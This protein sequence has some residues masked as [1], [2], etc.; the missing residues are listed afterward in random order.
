MIRGARSTRA[1]AALLVA[2]GVVLAS[3]TSTAD[4]SPAAASS[5]TGTNSVAIPLVP[6]DL[7]AFRAAE[8]KLRSDA[9]EKAG[10]AKLGPGALELA[11]FMD[12]TASFLLTDVPAR[13]A[14]GGPSG[15][16]VTV[17]QLAGG[18]GGRLAAPMI[19]LPPPGAASFG[20]Y[21]MT[22]YAFSELM[23][24]LSEKSPPGSLT[25]DMKP[26]TDTVT[27]AGNKGIITTLVT[28]SAQVSASKVSVLIRTK[29]T[30]EV[31]SAATN[32]V[33]FKID[34]EATGSATGDACPDSSGVARAKVTFRG[35]EEY[36]DASGGK[37]GSSTEDYG[38]DIQF[39]TDDSAKLAS[40]DASPT[41]DV[42]NDLMMAF[43][44]KMAAPGFEKAWRSGICIEVV[45]D[46]ESTSVD[47]DSVTTVNVKLRH[48]IDG[49]DLDKTVE[50]T[51]S[52]AKSLD[53]VGKK[54]KSPAT[55]QYTAG[56]KDDDEG[57][58]NFETVS[59][60]GVGRT[61]V[62]YTVGGGTWTVTS[63]GSSNERAQGVTKATLS[64]KIS[65][66]IT[67]A[68]ETVTGAKDPTLTG[69]GTMTV[70]GPVSTLIPNYMSCSGQ[71]DYTVHLTVTGTRAG[72]GTDAVLRLTIG[73]NA[74]GDED[75]LV[76]DCVASGYTLPQSSQVAPFGTNYVYAIGRLDLPASGGT[77]SISH[78]VSIGEL[79]VDASGTFTVVHNKV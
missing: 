77:K 79:N 13:L 1:V 67:S 9:R 42:G 14:A 49:N 47:R 72:S 50:A 10:L 7:A 18:P 11:G 76:M 2:C 58:M 70:T 24:K 32:A 6:V 25:T 62:R 54:M 38:S 4:Q 75:T 15:A 57:T 36:F 8:T 69:T 22:S 60:R 52:G 78:S 73:R 35:H 71:V 53:P 37:T 43:T 27:I 55:F 51:F 48:K 40:A 30:G 45:V 64:V 63:T 20:T 65:L 29:V 31:R 74:D 17:A 19:G 28:V 66:E 44:V 56:P 46:P 39:K 68:K 41:G 33:L 16:L 23:G 3:C 59:N 12:Q 34:S 5:G 26:T 61:F 21:F